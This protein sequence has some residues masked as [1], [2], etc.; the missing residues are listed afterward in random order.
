MTRKQAV[1]LVDDNADAR[2]VVALMLE[3]LGYSV[4]A[5]TGVAQALA[6]LS[7]G[8]ACDIVVT[9]FIM[10]D[11]SGLE[12]AKLVRRW[13]PKTPLILITGHQ[14]AIETAVDD[15]VVPLLKPFT[16]EQLRAVLAEA[17]RSRE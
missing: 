14:E 7:S 10:P 6:Q 11:T 2:Q 3:E 4:T 12:L 9:D 1:L 8:A 5:C 15:G 16:S 13:R 17:L